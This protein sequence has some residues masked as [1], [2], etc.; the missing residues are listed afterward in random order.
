MSGATAS[1]LFASSLSERLTDPRVV[2]AQAALVVAPL[3]V[4]RQFEVVAPEHP[5]LTLV[6]SPLCTLL[7]LFFAVDLLQRVTLRLEEQAHGDSDLRPCWRAITDRAL[8][9]LN[10]AFVVPLLVW[11][12][13]V[14]G[15][16]GYTAE[17]LTDLLGT[18][19]AGNHT[20]VGTLLVGGVVV[21]A[22]MMARGVFAWVQVQFGPELATDRLE[23]YLALRRAFPANGNQSVVP[24]DG[25]G[26]DQI[27]T[28]VLAT[29]CVEYT[30]TQV[31]PKDLPQ[32][33]DIGRIT[34]EAAPVTA[35]SVSKFV[36]LT[37]INRRFLV[38][39]FG[40]LSFIYA[41]AFGLHLPSIHQYTLVLGATLGVASQAV[42]NHPFVAPSRDVLE[43]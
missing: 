17:T 39:L 40:S 13:P 30:L 24:L 23:M 16:L 4:V 2:L 29:A 14:V 37:T 36:F 27:E 34:A 43:M 28:A 12:Q 15:T 41:G 42:Y 22:A 5:A 35:S 10:A 38:V 31:V 33:F 1:T 11:G 7:T 8:V 3:T 32:P 26:H 9:V 6:V 20:V 25:G 19:V 21:G 18:P